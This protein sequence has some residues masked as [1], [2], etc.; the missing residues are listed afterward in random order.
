MKISKSNFILI[1]ITMLTVL[2]LFQ[3]TNLS[4]LY[5]SKATTNPNAETEVEITAS[6]TIQSEQ[7]ESQTAYTTAIIGASS[8]A[9]TRLAEE[10]CTYQK[11]T[12]CRFEHLE[13]FY[14]NSS[15][16][17]K[18]LILSGDTITSEED[19]TYLQKVCNLGIHIIFTSLPDMT[20]LNASSSLQ[21]LLGIKKIEEPAIKTSAVT[22]FDGFLFGGKVTYK[23]IKPTVP[24]FYLRPG[25][26]TYMI[27]ELKEQKSYNIANED[28][29]PL[30]WRYASET[31]FVF[32]INGDY[33]QDYTGLG[34]LTSLWSDV[35]DYAIY[36]IANAQS[37]MIQNYPYA[38]DENSAE[39]E[40]QY[41]YTSKSLCQNVIWPDLVSI[42]NAT[43]D[44][45]SGFIAPKLEYDNPD[46]TVLSGYLE[47]YFKQTEKIQ[48]E[49]GLSGDLLTTDSAALY[50]QKIGQD[51]KK[52]QEIVPDYTFTAF[53]PGSM[54]ESVYKNYL[55]KEGNILSSIRTLLIN[56]Q[57]SPDALLSFYDET[58][59]SMSATNDGFSHTDRE[60]LYLRSI[61]TALGY[62]CVS[63]DLKRALYPEKKADD[64]TK[65]S[66]NL[67][68]Y[69]NSY[70][71][72]F[73][74]VFEQTVLSEADTNVR[75][76]L[77]LDYTVH[78]Q[79]QQINLSITNFHT[80]AYFVLELGNDTINS[81]SGGSYTQIEENTYLL[82]AEDENVTIE[83]KS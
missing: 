28:L 51:T 56:K 36:P 1:S 71:K 4:I 25:T 77:A 38:S 73:R 79:S 22:L 24:Y 54:P 75:R 58:I 65:L 40:K 49:L 69:L 11:R 70:W 55:G 42:L 13:D 60:D 41:Y 76:F 27:G 15:R 20:V 21:L 83:L 45:F 10:W 7:L 61:Q 53:A 64:W 72:P 26:K 52:L 2:F 66:K 6:Q 35:D 5:T 82:C 59:L 17:C 37:T 78:R 16:Q 47:F 3:F 34:M 33:C 23:K 29:P 9:G 44:K 18:L 81:I 43:N 12:Y 63:I 48:G 68:R 50:E 8:D 57:N 19:I 46:S 31:N 30:V 62:S 32:V 67:S 39:I 74:D 14:N 80:R